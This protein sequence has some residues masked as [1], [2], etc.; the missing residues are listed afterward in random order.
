MKGMFDDRTLPAEP[1]DPQTPPSPTPEER[2]YSRRIDCE[3]IPRPS[4]RE[5]TGET[6]R[7]SDPPRRDGSRRSW[8]C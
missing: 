1:A 5:G 4:T 8:Y 7:A 2:S 6:R 3:E